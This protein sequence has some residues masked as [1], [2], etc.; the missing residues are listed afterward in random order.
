MA[1]TTTNYK[2]DQ[3]HVINLGVL[4][5]YSTT[6]GEFYEIAK[7]TQKILYDSLGIQVNFCFFEYL[8]EEPNLNSDM[9]TLGWLS[10]KYQKI[11]KTKCDMLCLLISNKFTEGLRVLG[12]SAFKQYGY[13]SAVFWFKRRANVVAT[14]DTFVHELMHVIGATHT[15]DNDS[16]MHPNHTAE[17]LDQIWI[18]QQSIEE[19]YDHMNE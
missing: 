2:D 11:Y 13:G 10:D 4:L 12:R 7:F 5:T 8:I 15:P 17:E 6:P 18:C 9:T 19:I 3:E 16:I 14:T 1:D